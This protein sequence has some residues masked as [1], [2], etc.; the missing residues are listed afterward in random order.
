MNNNTIKPQKPTKKIVKKPNTNLVRERERERER[1]TKFM[2]LRE[3]R[4][5]QKKIPK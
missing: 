3:K 2:G 5:T 1:L 4:E